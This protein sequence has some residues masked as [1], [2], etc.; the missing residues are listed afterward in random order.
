VPS[1]SRASAAWVRVSSISSSARRCRATTCWLR[2]RRK[3]QGLLELTRLT[4]DLDPAALDTTEA[5]HLARLRDKLGGVEGGGIEVA[6]EAGEF[7][8]ALALA[9]VETVEVQAPGHPRG[10]P[11]GCRQPGGQGLT[12]ML[13]ACIKRLEAVVEVETV[14]VQ[15]RAGLQ[16]LGLLLDDGLEPLDASEQHGGIGTQI[17]KAGGIGIAKMLNAAHPGT[18]AAA[19]T[20]AARSPAPRSPPRRRPRAA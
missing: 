15:G 16:R 9:A 13:L 6:G 3:S 5:I 19:P 17:A 7:Q 4:R 1:E 18:P 11:D 12:A 20:D 10:R 14:E 8:E 2:N